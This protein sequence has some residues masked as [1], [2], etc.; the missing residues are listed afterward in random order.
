MGCRYDVVEAVLRDRRTSAPSM[1]TS[2]RPLCQLLHRFMARLDGERH[3]EIRAQFA[4][5]FTPKR[6]AAYETLIRDHARALLDAVQTSGAMDLV[7]GFARPLPFGVISD[8]LGVPTADQPWLE[9]TM[10]TLSA[11]FAGQRDAAQVDRGDQAATSL[12]GYFDEAIT[13]RSHTPRDDLLSLLAAAPAR[14]A[15]DGTRDDLAANCVFFLL[16]GHATTTTLLAAGAALLSAR[17]HDLAHLHANP[18]RWDQAIEELLRYI[19]PISITG[20]GVPHDVVVGDHRFL[21]G[22]NRLLCF[23][24]ANRDPGVFPDSEKLDIRRDPNRH[25]AFSVGAH[26]CLGAPLARLHGRVGLQELFARLPGF[27]IDG[28]P[29]TLPR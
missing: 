8:V 21:A 2:N 17:P 6:T 11:S 19:S 18:S 4:R 10:A 15:P 27:R 22:S 29:V 16:A 14:S 24:A 5:T 12:L 25:L 1:P 26:H 3:H 9:A 28:E 13:D 7:A 20:V 23:A